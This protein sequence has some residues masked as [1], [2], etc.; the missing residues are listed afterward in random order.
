MKTISTL[1][2]IFLVIA[3][4]GYFFNPE[5]K[6]YVDSKITGKN[7]VKPVYEIIFDEFEEQPK[8]VSLSGVQIREVKGANVDTDGK[9]KVK[10]ELFND[11]STYLKGNV[12]AY[13]ENDQIQMH[14]QQS[15]N[16][17]V[18]DYGLM[19]KGFSGKMKMM[20]HIGLETGKKSD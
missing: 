20:F 10:I 14:I 7:I 4:G 9:V 15:E 11:Y 3:A 12:F 19:I 2:A 13:S 17:S 16:E 6:D 8:S 18:I 5:I 1:F